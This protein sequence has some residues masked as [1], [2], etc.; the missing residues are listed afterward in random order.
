MRQQRGVLRDHTSQVRTTANNCAGSGLTIHRTL[1]VERYPDTDASKV[2]ISRYCSAEVRTV[3]ST[4]AIAEHD[5]NTLRKSYNA[6]DVL[7]YSLGFP[8]TRGNISSAL[9]RDNMN[10]WTKSEIGVMHWAQPLPGLVTRV[11]KTESADKGMLRGTNAASTEKRPLGAKKI[12]WSRGNNFGYHIISP[13]TRVRENA[14]VAPPSHRARR[15]GQRGSM[16]HSKIIVFR[17]RFCK[18]ISN[19]FKR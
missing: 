10:D 8:E 18:S 16:F 13:P 12:T 5:W 15:S 3:D 11:Q 1:D 14:A 6:W 4:S 19:L 17:A 7:L 9:T 2:C